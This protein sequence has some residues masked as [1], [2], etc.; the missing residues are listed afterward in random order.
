MQLLVGRASVGCGNHKDNSFVFID[1][2]EESPRTDSIPPCFGF[3]LLQFLDIG[4]EM[5]MLTQLGINE[6]I[7]LMLDSALTSHG[8]LLQVLLEL[9]GFEDPIFIQQT[10]LSVSAPP[11]N[12]S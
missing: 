11:E 10:A 5:G 7:K 9:I 12:P 1:F 4:P 2:I 8:D 6:L 3:K